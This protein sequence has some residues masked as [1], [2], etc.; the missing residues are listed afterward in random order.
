MRGT[1]GAVAAAL[2]ALVAPVALAA[3]KMAA[4]WGGGDGARHAWRRAVCKRGACGHGAH[5]AH[6]GALHLKA[7]RTTTRKQKK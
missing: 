7:R 6:R 4:G 3:A 1:Q 5:R 2:V